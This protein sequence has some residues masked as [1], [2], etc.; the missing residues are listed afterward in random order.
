MHG[1]LLVPYQ[2]GNTLVDV[3]LWAVFVFA[4]GLLMG[5]GWKVATRF[6]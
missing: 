3:V 6:P 1:N 4:F 5:W 2:T